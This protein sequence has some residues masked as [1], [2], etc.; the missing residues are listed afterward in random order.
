MPKD[1]AIFACALA[2]SGSVITFGV[3]LLFPAG[4]TLIVGGALFAAWVGTV[5][6]E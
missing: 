1:E 2:I 5:L 6:G 4:V 3:G